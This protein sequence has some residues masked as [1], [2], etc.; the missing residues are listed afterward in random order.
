MLSA[1]FSITNF[2]TE[3]RLFVRPAILSSWYGV[4]SLTVT[5]LLCLCFQG[6]LMSCCS[7]SVV[8]HIKFHRHWGIYQFIAFCYCAG[9]N[10]FWC[11]TESSMAWRCQYSSYYTSHGSSWEMLVIWHRLVLDLVAY[12]CHI[13][14]VSDT[15]GSSWMKGCWS[16]SDCDSCLSV[17]FSDLFCSGFSSRV[18]LITQRWHIHRLWCTV[19]SVYIKV[20]WNCQFQSKWFTAV[21]LPGVRILI[22][23]SPVGNYGCFQSYRLFALFW[24]R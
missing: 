24:N 17:W 7:Y 21:Q 18:W 12:S 3:I 14:H 1:W 23:I 9:W 8:R 11:S 16:S 10:W 19:Y 5:S 20:Y 4:V 22:F 2:W 15:C 13:P 6:G